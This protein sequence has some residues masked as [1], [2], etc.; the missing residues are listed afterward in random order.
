MLSPE[1][2]KKSGRVSCIALYAV[3]PPASGL[4]PQPWPAVSPVHT[5]L[6][7]S[8]GRSAAVRN[9]PCSV[10]P[11]EPLASAKPIR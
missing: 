9:E 1:W 11:T 4:I 3:I 7:G 5:K 10:C 8:V 6:T 2:M